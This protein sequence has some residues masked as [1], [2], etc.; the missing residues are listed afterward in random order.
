MT[1]QEPGLL[2]AL[3]FIC[4]ILALTTVWLASKLVSIR[5]QAQASRT[6]IEAPDAFSGSA[7]ITPAE[8]L[9][10]VQDAAHQLKTPLAVLSAR[11]AAGASHHDF[12]GA[13]RDIAW[14]SRLIEQLAATARAASVAVPDDGIFDLADVAATVAAALA[15]LAIYNNYDIELLGADRPLLVRG[16]ADLAI[17]AVSNLVQ[18]ALAHTGPGT[19]ITVEVDKLSLAVKDRGPGVPVEDRERIFRRFEQ[20]RR[21]TEGG[22]G[23]G[24]A[25]VQD[26]MRRHGGTVTCHERFDGGAEFRLTFCAALATPAGVSTCSREHPGKERYAAQ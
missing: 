24:L 7:A 8:A 2:L 4:I 22:T 25:I 26:I 18:N 11:L 14:M 5:R 15:P 17:E 10:F 20:G 12:V 3:M 13:H 23:L 21:P 9:A 16:N 6:S 1:E 19:T